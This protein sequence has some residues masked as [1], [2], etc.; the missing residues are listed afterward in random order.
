MLVAPVTDTPPPELICKLELPAVFAKV[1]VPPQ[2]LHVTVS[3]NAPDEIDATVFEPDP[4]CVIARA[5]IVKDG[6]E[7][8]CAA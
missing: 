5:V 6:A 4:D 3:V 7:T 2:P 1:S 8:A